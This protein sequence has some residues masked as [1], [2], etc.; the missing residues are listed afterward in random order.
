MDAMMPII[1]TTIRSS[2][3][4]KPVWFWR[5]II[6]SC[7]S[8]LG[9][10]LL[11]RLNSRGLQVGIPGQDSPS[12]QRWGR[13]SD[14]CPPEEVIGSSVPI[15][16][17]NWVAKGR[18]TRCAGGYGDSSLGPQDAALINTKLARASG[19]NRAGA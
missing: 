16:L 14:P 18:T 6:V 10:F 11:I 2:I 1:V 15:L 8:L 19:S 9:V 4:E 5:C 7:L 3:S 17:A 12:P 13:E